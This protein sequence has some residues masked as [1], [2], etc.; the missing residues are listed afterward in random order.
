MGSSN[1]SINHNAILSAVSDDVTAGM[2]V[3]K[4]SSGYVPATAANRTSYSKRADGIALD[5]GEAGEVIR[6]AHD[7]LVDEVHT[8]LGAGTASW[9]RVKD[10]ATLERCT[11][12][13]GNDL[14]GKCD[15]YGNLHATFNQFDSDNY[16]GGGGG[17]GGG[18]AS[19]PIDISDDG[20]EVTGDLSLTSQVTGTLP[21][22]N[23]GT[24]A[25]SLAA[26]LIQSDGVVLSSLTVASGFLTWAATPSSANLRSLVTDETGTGALVF[27]NT[28]T[29]VTPVIGAATGTSVALSSFW[30]TGA[31]PASTGAGRLSDGDALRWNNG[32]TSVRVLYQSSGVVSL[33]DSTDVSTLNL[34]SSGSTNIQ[35][36]GSVAI[37]ASATGVIHGQNGIMPWFRDSNGSAYYKLAVSDLAA[38]RT[39][40]LPLLTGNDTFVF[41]DFAATLTNKTIDLG[42][43]T[44]T[45]TSAQ[46]ATACS[47]E[48]GSGALVF[49]T[50]PTLSNP[51][52]LDSGS[53]HNYNVV[54]SDLAA[55]R[56]ITLPVLTGNDTFVFQAHSQ[57]L[58]NKVY[59]Q[60]VTAMAALAIDW[61]LGNAFTKTLAAGGNTLTFSNQSGGQTIIVR[62]TSNAGGSTVTWPAGV[63]WAGGTEPTQTSTGTDIYTLFYDGTTTYGSYVQAF[64]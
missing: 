44:V 35:G 6:V 46:L 59:K 54:A 8:I 52:F 53:N 30:S 12:A 41:N 17:G 57:T 11:P 39:I 50:T 4:L 64:S 13:S 3:L 31:S 62:L 49:G 40:T 60:V 5:D 1:F 26:G 25:S 47:N 21:I 22:A 51:K 14:V 42:S 63:Q 28:P 19:Y 29:L 20:V 38:D 48:T 58:T 9:V 34:N 56:N 45:F 33:G 18:D 32:G 10:D 23:G 36:G 7:G 27:A 37:T 55:D 24:G 61:S 16:A 2:A 43:N 15:V